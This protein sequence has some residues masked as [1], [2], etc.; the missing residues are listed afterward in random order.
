MSI[1]NKGD[2]SQTIPN[3]KLSCHVIELYALQGV[4]KGGYITCNNRLKVMYYLNSS[5]SFAML[6][7]MVGHGLLFNM[8]NRVGVFLSHLC[9]VDRPSKY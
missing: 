3:V 2:H 1:Y 7:S 9:H 8:I 4:Y 6:I 5:T